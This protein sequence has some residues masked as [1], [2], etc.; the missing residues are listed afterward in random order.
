MWSKQNPAAMVRWWVFGLLALISLSVMLSLPASASDMVSSYRDARNAIGASLQSFSADRPLPPDFSQ[1]YGQTVELIGRISGRLVVSDTNLL[2][3]DIGTQS[4]TVSFPDKMDQDWLNPGSTVRILV[5]IPLKDDYDRANGI[6]PM[7]IE[8]P[9][10]AVSA[11]DADAASKAAAARA[12]QDAILARK[13]ALVQQM[14]RS[15]N[16]RSASYNFRSSGQGHPIAPLSAAAMS[17][18]GPYRDTI[19]NLNPRLSAHAIDTITTSILYY[20]EQE[21]LDPRLVIAMIIAESGFNPSETSRTGAMGLGQLM[22][23]TAAGLGVTNPYDPVQNIGAAVHILSGNVRQY[24]GAPNGIVPMN[25]LMLTMAGYN[26]GN[27]AVK[28]YGGIPPFQETQ[29]YVRKVAKLYGEMCGG[30]QQA[31]AEAISE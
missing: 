26:A 1:L 6:L 24:G 21:H 13:A 19:Q 31:D 14:Q 12:A 29:R 30:Q 18:Y 5:A 15:L 10:G 22:P 25:T 9:D 11:A 2:I 27:G 17:I 4:E 28:R 16:S 23:E 7:L 8:A 3:M 20:S